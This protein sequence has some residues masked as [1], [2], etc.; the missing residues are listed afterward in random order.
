MAVDNLK[1]K[2][3]LLVPIPALLT[4]IN[5]MR[6]FDIP[7]KMW[8]IN[9]VC[10]LLLICIGLIINY[11]EKFKSKYLIYFSLFLLVL[12]FFDN[13]VMNVHRWVSLGSFKINIGLISTPI[14]IIEI[15]KI[16]NIQLAI[17]LS[18]MGLLVFLLQPD[19]SLV[20]AFSLSIVWVL[21]ERID[22]TRFRVLALLIS[23]I[24]IAYTWTYLDKLPPVEY[25]ENILQMTHKMG[26]L[27]A[28][29]AVVSLI[30]LPLLFFLKYPKNCKLVSYALGIYFTSL[31]ISTFFGNFP[32]MILGY[33]ISPIIGY[34][35]ALI[36]LIKKQDPSV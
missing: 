30:I 36:W 28:L 6:S 24:S 1:N 33:G 21:V 9:L 18:V 3:I 15:N 23:L 19:A 2:L 31:I 10:T 25:V 20:T 27:Y 4:G 7:K 16:K 12:P 8:L 35:M 14:L 32:V 34:Y 29:I 11:L 5:T 17:S 26:F 22:S 13:G